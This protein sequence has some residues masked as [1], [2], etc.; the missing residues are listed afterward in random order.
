MFRIGVGAAQWRTIVTLTTYGLLGTALVLGI[1]WF[2]SPDNSRW[3]PAVNTFTLVA[4]LTGILL[5]RLTAEAERRSQVLQAVADELQENTRLLADPR[6][7]DS[8]ARRRQVYPRL[9]VSAV[10]LALVSGALAR[11]RDAE[12]F[13]LLH[14]WRDGV[15]ELN[16]RL[17]LTEIRT[18]TNSISDEELEA[19]RRVLT[20]ENSYLAATREMLTRLIT[21][22]D[23]AHP[24]RS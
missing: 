6:F 21:S 14:R 12:L 4:G 15:H 18:F 19:F 1:A 3:E 10:D 11:Q 16:R 17:D 8:Q 23:A 22:L 5:E 9:V 7:A 13:G 20:S 24:S 2:V